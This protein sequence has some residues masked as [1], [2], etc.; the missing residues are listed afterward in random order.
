MKKKNKLQKVLLSGYDSLIFEYDDYEMRIIDEK[1]DRI[2]GKIYAC[3]DGLL[4]NLPA[5][6]DLT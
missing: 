2:I 1:T 4:V 5:S 3:K 6:K